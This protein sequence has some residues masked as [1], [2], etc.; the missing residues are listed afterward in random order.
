MSLLSVLSL[1]FKRP[2][3]SSDTL[4]C[5]AVYF[6]DIKYIW[7]KAYFKDTQNIGCHVF[8][9]FKVFHSLG[10]LIPSHAPVNSH[11]NVSPSG[12]YSTLRAEYFITAI[13][14]NKIREDLFTVVKW[15]QALKHKDEELSWNSNWEQIF[16]LNAF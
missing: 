3:L 14:H 6:H 9:F 5:G 1:A 16:F 7:Y 11:S 13:E 8:F 2:H 10:S 4:C 15:Y 12:L